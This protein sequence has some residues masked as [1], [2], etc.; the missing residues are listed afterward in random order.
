MNRLEYHGLQFNSAIEEV[1]RSNWHLSG[2]GGQPA[3]S[4][5]RRKKKE[6]SSSKSLL[7]INARALARR[8]GRGP[9]ST[10]EVEPALAQRGELKACSPP[11]PCPFMTLHAEVV[12]D[13]PQRANLSR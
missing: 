6:A 1:V 10:L 4:W 2:E 7:R 3:T 9:L 8:Q 12:L 13:R 5:G 11:N